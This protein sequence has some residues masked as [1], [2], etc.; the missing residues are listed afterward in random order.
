MGIVALLSGLIASVIHRGKARVKDA[1]CS[2]H[3]KQIGVASFIFAG[4]EGRFPAAAMPNTNRFLSPL[5][6]ILSMVGDARI[7]LCPTETDV[8]RRPAHD[9][10][11]LGRSNTSYFA[12]YTARMDQPEAIM[13]GDR[14]VTWNGALMTGANQFRRTYAFGWWRDMHRAKG[15]VLLSDGSVRIQQRAAN[16]PPE[17]EINPPQHSIGIYH[18][19]ISCSRRL[20]N[21]ELG[22]G[23]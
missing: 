4:E 22:F 3:L 20:M 15:N 7:F 16:S 2:S 9:L 17:S 8:N 1:G 6:P 18:M 21:D 23:V 11:L 5:Q 10:S 13:A 14:N 12:S 19:V